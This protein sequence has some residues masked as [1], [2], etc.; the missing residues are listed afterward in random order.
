MYIHLLT[1]YDEC[2]H[3]FVYEEDLHKFSDKQH[4]PYETLP[5]SF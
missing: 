4:I 2:V 3:V 1:M 5:S